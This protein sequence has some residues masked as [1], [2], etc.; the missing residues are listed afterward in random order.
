MLDLDNIGKYHEN[1]RIEAKKATGGLPDSLWETYSAFANTLGGMI[2][3][4]VEERADRSLHPIGLP[5]P[6]WLL[7]DLNDILNDT[8]KVSMNILSKDDISVHN[9]NGYNIIAIRVPRANRSCKPIFIGGDPY[10]GTYR[11]NGDGD[12]RCTK[13]EVEA[14]IRES[15]LYDPVEDTDQYRSIVE[16]VDVE[17]QEEL[18]KSSYINRD[19]PDGIYF[20]WCYAFWEI[21]KRLLHEKYNIEW[22]TPTEMNMLYESSRFAE[23]G[24]LNEK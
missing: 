10:T 19:S 7:M 22:R 16:D 18:E 12:Y 13:E 20:S 14:L 23:N 8:E 6:D 3:L 24:E 11:R 21:K 4:G 15:Q 17:A 1:N 9:S 5:D 2:L